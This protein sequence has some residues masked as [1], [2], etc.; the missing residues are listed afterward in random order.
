MRRD[1]IR[2]S[3]RRIRGRTLQTHVVEIRL[4]EI[5]H[6]GSHRSRNESRHR[7]SRLR[8]N[9]RLGNQRSYGSHH[10][11]RGS[12]RHHQIQRHGSRLRPCRLRVHRHHLRDRHHHHHHHHE[13]VPQLAESSRPPPVR[14]RL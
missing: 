11:R 3:S 1:S 4:G 5:L 14:T 13:R 6:R 2:H 10:R 7:G 9:Q 12:P 8:L